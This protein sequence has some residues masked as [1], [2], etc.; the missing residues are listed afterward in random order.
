LW[1]VP[2]DLFR[3]SY[4][5]A[6]FGTTIGAEAVA[7]A[8]KQPWEPLAKSLLFDPLGMRSSS[9]LHKDFIAAGN[10]RALLHARVADN[11]FKPLYDRDPDQQAPA[12]GVSS[13]AQDLA[14]WM[15]LL[16]AD[17]AYNG[18]PMIDPKILQPAITPQIVTYRGETP[19]TR[20]SS[21]G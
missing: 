1:M 5:Y 19:D 11:V 14:K 21:Y 9:Y 20:A 4:H 18:Q 13:S 10:D 15:I 6:N 12:G 16:L 2:L 8:E 3:I 7:H 17:G